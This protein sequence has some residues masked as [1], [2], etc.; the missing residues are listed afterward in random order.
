MTSEGFHIYGLNPYQYYSA[1]YAC[2]LSNQQIMQDS[3]DMWDNNMPLANV[4]NGNIIGYKYF[5]FGGLDKDQKGLKAFEGAKPGNKTAFNLFLAPKT[6]NAFKV[7]VWLDGPW[8]NETWKGKK[9]GEINVP[10]QCRA[11]SDE[12]HPGCRFGR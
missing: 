5:G 6:A 1:G 9:I 3:W 8:D 11:G 12:I 2:Y 7:N 10:G 4:Q